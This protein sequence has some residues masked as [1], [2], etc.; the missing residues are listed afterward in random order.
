MPGAAGG[1]VG[2]AIAVQAGIAVAAFVGAFFVEW[3]VAGYHLVLAVGIMPLILAVM[4]YFIPVLTRTAPAGAPV[5]LAP[6]LA[7][8]GGL[9][10]FTGLLGGPRWLFV[11]AAAAGMVAAIA[12]GAWAL[13]RADEAIGSPHPCLRWYLAALTCLVFALGATLLMHRWPGQYQA[14][15]RFHLH[16]NTL[17]FIALTAF[18]TLQVL[19]PTVAGRPDAAA[20]QRLSYGLP[21]AMGGAVLVA[22]GA[23]WLPPLAWAGALLWFAA[24]CMLLGVWWRSYRDAFLAL[25]GAAPLLAAAVLGF[26]IIVGLGVLHAAGTISARDATPAFLTGVLFPLVTGALTH[27]LPLWISP[28]APRVQHMARRDR[29][30]R[31][32]VV[33]VLM[34]MAAGAS[35]AMGVTGAWILA[36]AG[37]GW[38]A[39]KIPWALSALPETL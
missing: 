14:I 3:S 26:A 22:V 9:A 6:A 24:A 12:L 16:L 37:V 13:W 4:S 30:G 5:L 21:V 27:L 32:S 25:H 7:L 23:A 15:R 28:Q 17:G 10:V 39:L 34:F 33:S 8:A 18:A 19:M 2:R 29:I 20:A 35:L 1:R 36:V 11:A 38:F 31:W